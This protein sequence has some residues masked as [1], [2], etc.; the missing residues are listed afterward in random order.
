MSDLTPTGLANALS[1]SVPYASQ[2]LGGSREMPRDL[3]IKLY[4]ATGLK[5]GPIADASDEQIETLEQFPD[6]APMRE[7]S[8]Q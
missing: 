3:A 1:I 4:R 5:M 7:Q 8:R 6:R 2:L